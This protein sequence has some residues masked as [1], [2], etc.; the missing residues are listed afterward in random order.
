MVISHLILSHLLADYILQT[1]WLAARKGQFSARRI[2]S[3]DGLLLH[4]II[5]WMVSMAALPRYLDVLWPYITALAIVHILQDATKVWTGPRIEL[6]SIIPYSLDQGL[7]FLAIFAFQG[8]VAPLIQPAPSALELRLVMLAASLIALT[9]MYEVSWWANWLDMIPY[10]NRWRLWGYLERS[11]MFLL[12]AADLWW[13][14]PLGVLPRLYAAWR[15][16]QPIWH[17]KHGMA[18]LLL[19]MVFSVILGFA[20]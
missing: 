6:Q 16:G 8:L 1:N 10:M 12:S 7:H 20:I 5:V 3:W 4:G 14:A 2:Q 17:Q 11:A 13:L 19:G 15:R 18:E 9:R